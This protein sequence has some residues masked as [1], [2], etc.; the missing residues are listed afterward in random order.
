MN[1][2]L[3]T[4]YIFHTFV[5]DSDP[6]HLSQVHVH[7]LWLAV[8]AASF[9]AVAIRQKTPFVFGCVFNHIH[10]GICNIFMGLNSFKQVRAL[11]QTIV[12]RE[13]PHQQ[14]M[15]R[16]SYDNRIYKR[17]ERGQK[18]G[19]GSSNPKQHIQ[20]KLCS[21][22]YNTK[23]A[24]AHEHNQICSDVIKAWDKPQPGWHQKTALC[25]E[26]STAP[27]LPKC[28]WARQ[29]MPTRLRSALT[30]LAMTFGLSVSRFKNWT[31][32]SNLLWAHV[33]KFSNHAS[34]TWVSYPVRCCCRRCAMCARRWTAPA[35]LRSAWM[36]CHRDLC[37]RTSV[38]NKER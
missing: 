22:R 34:V 4:F 10:R 23:K 32:L 9:K 12:K 16:C 1:S 6:E 37:S 7:R 19:A 26:P 11:L 36:P 8:M 17:W 14:V 25:F 24:E 21:L 35:S 5:N 15:T 2:I 3:S 27:C 13:N 33:T 20:Y 30:Q 38:V 28:P 18:D 31:S 29:R